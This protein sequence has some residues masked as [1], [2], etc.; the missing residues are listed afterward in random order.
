MRRFA[1]EFVSITRGQQFFVR[2]HPEKPEDSVIRDQ[3]NAA[4]IALK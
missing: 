2:Y 3:D 1:E 4:L